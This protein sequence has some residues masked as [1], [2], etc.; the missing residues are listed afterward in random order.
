MTASPLIEIEGLRVVFHGDDGRTTR[1]VDSVD[2]SVANGA[3]L[4]LVGKSG[5][6]KSVTV[7][8]HPGARVGACRRC[9]AKTASTA[10]TCWKRRPTLREVRGNRMAMIFQEPMTSLNPTFTVGDQIIETDPAPSR[11]LGARG[12]RARDRAAAP[13]PD[14]SPDE[15][16]DDYPHEFSGGM[17][18]RVMI[19]IA[20]ACD[21]APPDRGRADH[22]ARR[23][24]AG[25]DSRPPARAEGRGG[26]AIILIT[27]DLGVV[28]EICDEVAVMYAGQIVEHA[29]VDELFA[30]PQHPYTIGLLGSLPRLGAAPAPGD[31][32]RHGAELPEPAVRLPVPPRCP[33]RRELHRRAAA[34]RGVDRSGLALHPGAARRPGVMTALLASTCA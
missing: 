14:P 28:A 21:P 23:H 12:A 34:A 18:Q 33:F 22:R 10:S 16:I 6:G 13:R 19:A 7:A 24:D 15:R 27:H 11:R 8:G 1:A 30:T 25:A 32:R 20:L 3:T 2:L 26:A 17:R 4:G 31:H 29:P 9:A 5:S